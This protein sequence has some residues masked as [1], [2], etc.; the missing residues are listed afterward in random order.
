MIQRITCY[1]GT[2][3]EPYEN[4]AVE[5]FLMEAVEEGELILYLW[6]NRR[7]VVIGRNQNPWRE[8]RLTELQRDG[9]SLARRLSGGGAVYHDLGNLN[10]TFCVQGMD[11]DL[12]RQQS[13]ILEACHLLGIGAELSG[14]ND[15]LAEGRKFS[16]NSF[17]NHNGYAFHNGTLLVDAD[18]ECIGKY[19]SP[20]RMKLEGKG[21]DSVRSRVVNLAELHPG[22]TVEHM[23]RAMTKALESIYQLPSETFSAER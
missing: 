1:L 12:R 23:C 18:L 7:T 19:L 3:T 16:G 13:V 14:R 21:V 8:C 11:Y 20:S 15:L 4:L 10:F 5:R 9:G 6:Q 22:L 2:G 17:Y